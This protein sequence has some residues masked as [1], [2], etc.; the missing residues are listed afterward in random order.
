MKKSAPRPT[1]PYRLVL[2]EWEDSQR[3]LA[4]WGWIDEL[5]APDPSN[6]ISVG[7]LVAENKAA[8]NIAGTVADLDYQRHQ[9][10]GIVTIPR[11]AIKRIMDL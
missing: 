9:A 6:C 5:A 2:V 7:Y 4:G 1:S 10:C 8:I 3:P 11:R